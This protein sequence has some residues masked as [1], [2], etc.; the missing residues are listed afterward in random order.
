MNPLVEA[1]KLSILQRVLALDAKPIALIAL[2][3]SVLAL[4]VASGRNV[5][6]LADAAKLIAGEAMTVGTSGP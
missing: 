4:Y 6:G 5:S 1:P 2:A 3:V